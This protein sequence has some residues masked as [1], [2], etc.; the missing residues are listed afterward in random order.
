MKKFALLVTFAFV[1]FAVIGAKA[2]GPEFGIALGGSYPEA[3]AKIGFDSALKFN[4]KANKLFAIGVESGFGW[5]SSEKK[6]DDFFDTGDVSLSAISSVNFYSVPVLGV[7]TLSLPFGEDAPLSFFISGGAGYSWT[8]YKGKES[9]PFQ[10]F[11][12]QALAGLAYT[13]DEEFS[14]MKIFGEVGYRGTS[15]KSDIELSAG[16]TKQLALAMSAPFVRIGVAF[17]LGYSEY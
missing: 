9:H 16:Q 15:V 7:I 14:S 10:G 4:Y 5:V 11:T 6:E 12:W 13:Y 2:Q 8:F 17:P 3:P 1:V